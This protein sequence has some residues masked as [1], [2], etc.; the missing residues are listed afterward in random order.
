MSSTMAQQLGTLLQQQIQGAE[1]LQQILKSENDALVK[2]DFDVIQQLSQKKS[3]Q[4]TRLEH[5][6]Q[7]QRQLL[8]MA[9]YAYSHEGINSFINSL[10]SN[11]ATELRKKQRQLQTLLE[12]C[13]KLNMV[14]GNIIAANKHSAETALA[15]LRGQFA[16]NL[17]Y[18]A[19]GQ[20]VAAPSS[21]PS[22]KA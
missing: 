21:K 20:A 12:E 18:G 10:A 1:Q 7:Q 9:G 4:S 13:Q 19:S 5:L 14:N 6:G 17:M 8:Q 11:L 2:R 15:I 3:E 16:D 22:I